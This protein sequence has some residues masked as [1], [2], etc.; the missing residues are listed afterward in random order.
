MT[1][2]LNQISCF[3]IEKNGKEHIVTLEQLKND[4]NGAPRYKAVIIFLG[5]G[6]NNFN[7]A[8]YT[9]KGHYWNAKSEAEFILDEYYQSKGE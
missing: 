4:A 7:N 2:R 6:D 1:K 9:F 8:V 3:K 5:S